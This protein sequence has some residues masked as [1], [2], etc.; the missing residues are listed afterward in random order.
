MRAIRFPALPYSEP[1][2]S[3]RTREL[4]PRLEL[5][6]SGA[7]GKF[8]AG[9]CPDPPGH[10]ARP[11]SGN[12]AQQGGLEMFRKRTFP[13]VTPAEVVVGVR[14][15]CWWGREDADP[16][17]PPTAAPESCPPY[18]PPCCPQPD[19]SCVVSRPLPNEPTGHR[20]CPHPTNLLGQSSSK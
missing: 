19:F 10:K 16:Q 12:G 2:K 17:L 1:S 4:L 5:N 6:L 13:L 7:G 20:C 15:W 18:L 11:L 14:R 8:M 9:S 3:S